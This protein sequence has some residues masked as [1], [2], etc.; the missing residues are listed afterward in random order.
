MVGIAAFFV[1]T[2]VENWFW[3]AIQKRWGREIG[4]NGARIHQLELER[5]RRQTETHAKMRQPADRI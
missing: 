2:M 3:S 1:S 5:E 4:K